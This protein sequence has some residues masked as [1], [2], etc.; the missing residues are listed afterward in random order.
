MVS[1][2]R[3]AFVAIGSAG[4]VALTS[5][6]ILEGTLGLGIG[7][8]YAIALGL[9]CGCLFLA[10]AI[11][12]FSFSYMKTNKER[13]KIDEKLQEQIQTYTNKLA[14]NSL[15]LEN[16]NLPHLGE[17]AEARKRAIFF[18]L[19]KDISELGMSGCL[20]FEDPLKRK[21]LTSFAIASDYNY[22]F[23]VLRKKIA[24]YI[25][26]TAK[27]RESKFSPITAFRTVFFDFVGVF[28]AITGCT[29][30]TMGL[31]IS[32]GI[33]AGFGSIPL[34]GASILLLGVGL[35]TYSALQAFKSFTVKKK[36][37][38]TVKEMKKINHR[39]KL[40][41]GQ[42]TEVLFQENYQQNSDGSQRNNLNRSTQAL[43]LLKDVKVCF[44]NSLDPEKTAE[45]EVI[46]SF[47][48]TRNRVKKTK[49][50]S[51]GY[52]WTIAFRGPPN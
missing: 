47:I 25:T 31:L 18:R 6:G 5:F 12:G 46:V 19:E 2:L 3:S 13:K 32:V 50:P 30:G 26:Y 34:V 36:K 7:S 33:T 41:I 4:G 39:V 22:R 1:I 23:N 15:C 16:Y 20:N 11:T 42:I 28:G 8:A 48:K 10:V 21:K 24:N 51:N 52:F 49:V 17:R 9:I 29:A 35:G 37:I 27:S 45:D 44:F 40:A 38:Q 14:R 43:S